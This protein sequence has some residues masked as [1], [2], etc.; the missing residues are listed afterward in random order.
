MA[1]H[2]QNYVSVSWEDL[3]SEFSFLGV[4]GV[5]VCRAHPCCR[6]LWFLSVSHARSH[7]GNGNII[8]SPAAFKSHFTLVRE[9][10]QFRT[11]GEVAI[12]TQTVSVDSSGP[13]LGQ[14]EAQCARTWLHE[15]LPYFSVSMLDTEC[16]RSLFLTKA[17]VI[18]LETVMITTSEFLPHRKYNN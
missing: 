15:K 4:C 2:F 8:S 11:H 7:K 5:A 1:H 3:E 6:M 17:C 12:Q 14:A 18:I 16:V 10:A 9:Y 13:I